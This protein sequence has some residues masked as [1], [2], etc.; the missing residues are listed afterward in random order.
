MTPCPNSYFARDTLEVAHDLVG[1]LL[2][3]EDPD[4]NREPLVGR[5]VETEAYTQDDP[6]FHGWN[7]YDEE[8]DTVRSE[9]RGADLF[10]AP[11]LGYVYLC[12]GVHW[13]LNVVTEPEGTGGAV[14]IRAVEPQSGIDRMRSRR[15][16][17]R[18]RDLTNGPGKLTEAFD[19][20]EAFHQTSLTESPLFFVA[21]ALPDSETIVTSSRIGISKAVERPWRFFVEGN[22]F[23]SPATPSAQKA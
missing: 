19:I 8:T 21:D 6:A 18:E 14:L 7:L 9:G 22:R 12:Y 11:G 17:R 10:T 13:L 3:R 4:G 15:G 23:V 16:D 2:V 20:D 1:A 5:I